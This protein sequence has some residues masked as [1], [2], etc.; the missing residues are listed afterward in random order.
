MEVEVQAY[1]GYFR[2]D[3]RFIPDSLLVKIP[4]NKRAIVNILDVEV[5]ETKSRSQQQLEALDRFVDEIKSL[6]EQG[7]EPLT[8]EDFSAL[9]NNRVT[10]NR[11]LDL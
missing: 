7:I 4:T 6:D 11:S 10:F 5:V 1:Q 2:E 9:E 3:G 8:D